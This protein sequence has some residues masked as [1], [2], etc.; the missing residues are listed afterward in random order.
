MTELSSQR[1]IVAPLGASKFSWESVMWMSCIQKV[2][3]C[4]IHGVGRSLRL[5][6]Y[7]PCQFQMCTSVDCGTI[8][9][10]LFI[11]LIDFICKNIIPNIQ[12]RAICKCLINLFLMKVIHYLC[13][14]NESLCIICSFC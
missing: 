13:W 3:K 5:L 7:L 6:S 12:I 2:D 10:R 11:L 14:E 4:H 8:S 9:D 1:L